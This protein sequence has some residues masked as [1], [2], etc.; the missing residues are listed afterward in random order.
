[1]RTLRTNGP[2]TTARKELG[3]RHR[4]VLVRRIDQ[5]EQEFRAEQDPIRRR[6]LERD[7]DHEI[8]LMKLQQRREM[9]LLVR[10][11][12]DE[13]RR[14]GIDPDA[15][16]IRRRQENERQ[17][18]AHLRN[19]FMEQMRQ[20][21]EERENPIII[22]EEDEGQRVAPP[23]RGD[24][25]QFAQDNQNVHT[26]V[27]VQQ[28]KEAVERILKIPVPVEYRWNMSECSKTPGDIIMCC[29]LTPKG[30]WQ[31]QAKYCQDEEIYELGK[32]I[33]GKVLDGVWQYILNSPDKLDLCKILKQEMEDNIG[34]CAQGNLT[35][36]CNILSGY[37]EGIGVKES[38]AEVLGRKLPL[39]MEIK[40][41]VERLNEA[42][43]IFVELGIPENQWLSWAEP[44]VECGELCIQIDSKGET[45]GLMIV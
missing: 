42:Y 29:K 8:N 27:A 4:A 10:L 26:T 3:Y 16:A 32:G 19:Q 33:Y 15:E 1:M 40:D 5:M 9:E 43:K 12:Q 36:L 44:L 38:P 31:M 30:A 6:N 2:N 18:L 28:T 41:Q 14:T 24:L 22:V 11:Q 7:Q 37:M 25:A 23:Q 45:T 34:M 39:L 20:I 17:R 21:R 35:R 13:I